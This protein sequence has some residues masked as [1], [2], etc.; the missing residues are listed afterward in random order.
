MTPQLSGDLEP[1]PL[2][3]TLGQQLKKVTASPQWNLLSNLHVGFSHTNL[4]SWGIPSHPARLCPG[5]AFQFPPALPSGQYAHLSWLGFG[6]KKMLCNFQSV[7][8]LHPEAIQVVKVLPEL[9]RPGVLPAA[10]GLL[11]EYSSYI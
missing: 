5:K 10:Q 4:S 11:T 7:S 3:T 8:C 2:I 1:N 9:R 6:I